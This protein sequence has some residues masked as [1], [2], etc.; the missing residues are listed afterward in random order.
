MFPEEGSNPLL[1]ASVKLRQNIDLAMRILLA[2]IMRQ[3]FVG[4][5]KQKPRQGAFRIKWKQKKF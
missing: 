1:I 4:F 2:M 3:V 5:K